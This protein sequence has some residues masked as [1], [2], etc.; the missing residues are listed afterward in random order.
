[1]HPFSSCLNTLL[2]TR[3]IKKTALS[4]HL[5]MDRSTLHQFLNGKRLPASPEIIDAIASYLSLSPE[6]H[7]ALKE[8]WIIEKIT[9]QVYYRR[10]HVQSFL[11][12]YL[13]GTPYSDHPSG[14]AICDCMD[15]IMDMPLPESHQLLNGK[16]EILKY[17]RQIL[18][19]E[20]SRPGGRIALCFQP[21][22]KPVMD[23]IRR[24]PSS[25]PFRMDHIICLNTTDE[26]DIRKKFH[27]LSLF[28]EI[29]PFYRK[30]NA[31][32]RTFYHYDDSCAHFS[33][34]NGMPCLFLTS[35]CTIVCQSDF[36]K[37]ILY[38]CKD[39]VRIYWDL[40]RKC[41]QVSPQLLHVYPVS[42]INRS[43]IEPL[44]E[45]YIPLSPVTPTC[46]NICICVNE[47]KMAA[48]YNKIIFMTQ[49]VSILSAI[50]DYLTSDSEEKIFTRRNGKEFLDD[51]WRESC[52][53]SLNS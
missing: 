35:D 34:L 10:R 25:Y 26:I 20:V 24:L 17:L 46:M 45:V 44:E 31:T 5:N 49:E 43:L 14:C 30:P 18:S 39:C 51:L 33:I 21:D 3:N 7:A 9:P 47:Q 4:Q 48:I 12:S 15:S 32:Y 29:L 36:Q 16:R 1:M 38:T 2:T 6:E 13:L 8:A 37:G 19:N 52:Q 28:S 50:R 23:L 42:E 27:N 40:F 11:D 53:P 22:Q 41:R